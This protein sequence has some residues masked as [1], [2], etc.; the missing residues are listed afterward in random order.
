MIGS[1]I[2]ATSCRVDRSA[3]S[4]APE[5]GYAPTACPFAEMTAPRLVT[6]FDCGAGR[7]PLRMEIR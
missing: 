7:D 6:N 4:I 3:C 1:F 2:A 5:P